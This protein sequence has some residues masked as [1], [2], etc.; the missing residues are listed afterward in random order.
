MRVNR[1]GARSA[2]ERIGKG[3]RQRSRLRRGREVSLE[4]RRVRIDGIDVLSYEYPRLEIEV[5]CGKGTYIRSLARDL[6]QRL[7]CGGY[8]ET[9]RRT[10]VGPFR[11][12]EAVSL[13]D[14]GVTARAKVLP[15]SAALAELPRVVI[16]DANHVFKTETHEPA[17][18]SGQQIMMAYA[19]EGHDLAGGI[20]DSIVAFVSAK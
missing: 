14:D 10:R 19:D 17:S 9:L 4:A 20:V 15:V 5:R 1:I 7:G 3:C 11:V 6:G 2:A 12:E 13:D 18:L 16:A 8:V